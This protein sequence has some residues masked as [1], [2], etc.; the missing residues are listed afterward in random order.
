[1]P[2]RITSQ[3]RANIVRTRGQAR[4][5]AGR[6]AV[7][8]LLAGLLLLQQDVS[9]NTAV[10]SEDRRAVPPPLGRDSYRRDDVDDQRRDD[11]LEGVLL[12]ELADVE[13][14]LET[15]T[16]RGQVVTLG[17]RA[18]RDHV[19]LP[20][21]LA[22][23]VLEL[24]AH[25][26]TRDAVRLDLDA[27]H[28]EAETLTAATASGYHYAQSLIARTLLPE[29]SCNRGGPGRIRTCDLGIKSPA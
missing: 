11:G 8:A 6:K 28:A 16:G 25:E 15:G 17:R 23:E 4:A 27:S 29:A 24:L 7:R 14:C 20:F 9:E 22:L 3:Y 1:M 19:A 10:G 13:R 18:E 5:D 26:A 21:E 12:E 2:L